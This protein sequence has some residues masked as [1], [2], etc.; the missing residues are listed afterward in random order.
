MD[1]DNLPKKTFPFILYFLKSH[2]LECLGMMIIGILWSVDLS[3]RPY[4]I[5]VMLD[6]LEMVSPHADLFTEL[7]ARINLLE[8][9][10][11]NESTK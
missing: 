2:F 10:K 9:L 3:L 8:Q 6:K 11:L 4:L 5:K 7:M 1:I